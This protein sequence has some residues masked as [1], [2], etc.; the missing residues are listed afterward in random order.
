M[1]NKLSGDNNVYIEYL[2]GTTP[3][4]MLVPWGF[5]N[6]YIIYYFLTPE[7]RSLF[8]NRLIKQKVNNEELLELLNNT[9]TLI[10]SYRE[11]CNNN[12]SSQQL[13][14]TD[15][16]HSIKKHSLTHKVKY[17]PTARV[18]ITEPKHIE[19]INELKE[20]NKI[21]YKKSRQIILMLSKILP[22]LNEKDVID[23]ETVKYYQTNSWTC[24]DIIEDFKL[25][26]VNL[27]A[28]K[29]QLSDKI[30]SYSK[31]VDELELLKKTAHLME[32]WL[33]ETGN[34]IGDLIKFN[35]Y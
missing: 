19:D 31:K 3:E 4:Y 20:L 16:K 14:D 26:A 34:E 8:F 23:H 25:R 10:S 5:F 11:M 27:C 21:I 22:A 18:L 24:E 9:K 15:A 30:F 35:D 6:G 12:I 29:R 7:I 13:S 33:N 28:D 32:N 17:L 2:L 1:I